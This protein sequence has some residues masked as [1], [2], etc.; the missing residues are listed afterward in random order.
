LLKR[1]QL[2]KLVNKETGKKFSLSEVLSEGHFLRYDF[3]S[4]CMDLIELY[5]RLDAF[6]GMAVGIKNFHL[7]FPT[8][9][10][11]EDPHLLPKHFIIHCFQHLLHTMLS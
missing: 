10:E 4:Q 7:S 9:S 5:C 3:K 2:Q 6:Y 11:T 1:P 8:F